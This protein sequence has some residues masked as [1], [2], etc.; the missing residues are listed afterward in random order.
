MA[1]ERHRRWRGVLLAA[2]SLLV[3]AVVV[4]SVLDAQWGSPGAAERLAERRAYYE[5]VIAPA[6]L[7]DREALFYEVIR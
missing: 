3:T 4:E 6:G 5:K 1:S 7:S 2:A